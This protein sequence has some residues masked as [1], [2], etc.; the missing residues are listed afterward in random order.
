MWSN[1]RVGNDKVIS[2]ID[3]TLVCEKWSEILAGNA[4]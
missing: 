2:R 4:M 3:R 1:G